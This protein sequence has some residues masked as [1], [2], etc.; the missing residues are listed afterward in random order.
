[1]LPVRSA[2]NR[3]NAVTAG[4]AQSVAKT[5]YGRDIT[6]SECIVSN[7]CQIFRQIWWLACYPAFKSHKCACFCFLSCTPSHRQA[8]D[9]LTCICVPKAPR[10][11]L[12]PH[13]HKTFS[14]YG[15]R[16]L[17][18]YCLQ[19]LWVAHS[20]SGHRSCHS[21]TQCRCLTTVAGQKYRHVHA[22]IHAWLSAFNACL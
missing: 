17:V 20:P 5:R 14:I 6:L 18:S 15:D 21:H 13:R 9:L 10:R 2:N 4:G 1:M 3:S 22:F 8:F 16:P 7:N 11:N 12:P 19:A